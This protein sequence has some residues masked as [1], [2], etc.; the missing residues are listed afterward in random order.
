MTGHMSRQA[1]FLKSVLNE[2]YLHKRQQQLRHANTDQINAVS[3]LVMN[4]FFVSVPQ[5]R[6]TLKRLKPYPKQLRVL[7]NPRQSIKRRRGLMMHQL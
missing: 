3:E 2:A 1:V 4:T 6:Q 5:V 7:S